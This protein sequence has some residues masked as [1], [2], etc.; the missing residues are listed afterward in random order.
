MHKIDV[1][2]ADSHVMEV[3]ETWDYLGDEFRD[4]KPIVVEGEGLAT[5]SH[6]DAWWLIDGQ[7]HPRLWGP[8]T[9]FSGTPLEMKF[10]RDKTFNIGSQ[11]MTD[12]DARIRDLDA[13]GI[14]IQVIYS[15]ILFHRLTED[16]RFEAALMRSYN[17]WISQR[18]NER[19]ER[20]KWAAVIPMRDRDA[21][22]AEVHRARE[23]GAVGLMIGGTAGQTLLH[24]PDLSPFYA[25]ACEVDLPVCIHTGWSVPGLTQTCE[26][27]YASL[28]LSF[29]LP[30]MMGFFSILGGGVLDRFPKLRV[31]FLEAGSEWIPYMV[32]RMD[33]YHPVVAMLGNRSKKLPSEYLAEGRVYVTCEAEE[34]LLPQ[35][36]DLVGED[37]ILIEGDIP[38]AEARET[39]IEELRERTD[40]SEAV[41]QKILRENGLAFYK[42]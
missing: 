21:C 17:T 37:Q 9:T 12:I 4:R 15:S 38:H 1:V 24:H 42:L 3:P 29:T 6:I 30:V 32:G 31:A 10:A 22:V 8:G 33:H 5:N 27:P 14:D 36:I 2:D 16:P 11:G 25:A 19:P 40:I 18:C 13:F 34:P 26:D 39:G 7:I 28:I 35:V 23:L 41:K 20:L